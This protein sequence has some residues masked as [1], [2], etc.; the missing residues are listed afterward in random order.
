MAEPKRVSRGAVIPVIAQHDQAV[1]IHW[2]LVNGSVFIERRNC[3]P[4]ATV[5]AKRAGD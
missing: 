5:E 2:R 1:E 3:P 4:T